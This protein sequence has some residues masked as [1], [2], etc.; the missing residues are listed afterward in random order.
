MIKLRDHNIIM[1]F[2]FGTKKIGVAVGQLI[3]STATPVSILKAK[4]GIPDWQKIRQLINEWQPSLLVIGLPL[5]MDGSECEMS[6]LSQKF[7]RK[8]N[9]R[10]NLPVEMMDERLTSFEAKELDKGRGKPVDDIAAK[11]ILESF[12]MESRLSEDKR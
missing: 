5:N 7:A 3:T 1:C 12:F 10:F 2:D 11:I 8:L 9:G 4:N 6:R